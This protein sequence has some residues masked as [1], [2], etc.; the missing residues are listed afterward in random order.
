MPLNSWILSNLIFSSGL[1]VVAGLVGRFQSQPHLRRALWLLVLAKLVTPP[2]FEFEYSWPSRLPGQLTSSFI[3]QQEQPVAERATNELSTR[4]SIHPQRPIE[5]TFPTQSASV[6]SVDTGRLNPNPQV[7]SVAWSLPRFA[8]HQVAISIWISGSAIW[9]TIVIIRLLRFHG[10]LRNAKPATD[11]IRTEVQQIATAFGLRRTPAVV[12]VGAHVPPLIWS[13]GRRVQLILP[14]T[15]CSLED[16]QKRLG[17]LA[18]EL[19]HLRRRDHWV[20]WFELLVLGLFWWN[21]IA[22]WARRE[23]QQAEEECCDRWVLWAYPQH[24]TAFAESLLETVDYLNDIS[25]RRLSVVTALSHGQSLRRRIEMLFRPEIKRSPPSWTRLVVAVLVTAVAP[26]SVVARGQIDNIDPGAKGPAKFRPKV[27]KRSALPIG[28]PPRRHRQEARDETYPEFNNTIARG[29]LKRARN[30]IED[31]GVWRIYWRDRSV[32]KNQMQRIQQ[33]VKQYSDDSKKIAPPIEVSERLL[34]HMHGDGP[35][36]K[37]LA[38]L[39]AIQQTYVQERQALWAKLQKLAEAELTPQQLER[40]RWLVLKE[41]YERG[42][43]L[44]IVYS[45]DLPMVADLQ[46]KLT[47]DQLE[48]KIDEVTKEANKHIIECHREES[49]YGDEL[50]LLPQKMLLEACDHLGDDGQKLRRLVEQRRDRSGNVHLGFGENANASLEWDPRF[51]AAALEAAKDRRFGISE[52]QGKQIVEYWESSGDAPQVEI[53]GRMRSILTE[54]QIAEIERRVLDQRYQSDGLVAVLSSFDLMTI[55]NLSFDRHP[56]ELMRIVR[57]A[58]ADAE[59][60]QEAG[61]P[62]LREMLADAIDC[63]LDI[64][65]QAIEH[66]LDQLGVDGAKIRKLLAEIY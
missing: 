26:L 7:S 24:A 27:L 19:A 52:D 20:R 40:V 49:E 36:V 4:A 41:R 32:R 8:V 63:S 48:Q 56:D 3:L 12:S 29:R 51:D 43:L 64:Q 16:P 28:V 21:P 34:D 13:L 1:A 62:R 6:R 23:A 44:A 58:I 9:F 45:T 50:R 57:A 39:E 14:S 61:Q 15:L 60:Q 22:W 18:H 38:E 2:I 59:Q 31:W 5:L 33:H 42:G 55:S 54:D 11:S 47:P 65:E 30:V 66:I 10:L 46:L 25:T 35:P 53:N 37:N 17:I